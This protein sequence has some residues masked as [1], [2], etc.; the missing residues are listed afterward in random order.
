MRLKNFAVSLLISLMAALLTLGSCKKDEFNSDAGFRLEFSTDTVLFDTVFTSVGSSVRS[1]VIRNTGDKKINISKVSLAR[2]TSSPFRLN[3]D[4]TAAETYE[5]LEIGANDSAYIFV[6]VTIDPKNASNP[7]IETDSVLFET[8]GNLQN[9][10]LVAWGQDAYFH[11]DV[12]LSGPVIL[13]NDK[14]HVIY[15]KLTAAPDCDLQIP[16]GSRLYFHNGSSF[17]VRKGASLDVQGTI[18]KPVIFTSDRLDDDYLD[19]PG[20]WAGIWLENGCRNIRFSNTE[21]TNARIGIQ[22][23]STGWIDDE[24]LRLHNCLIHNMTNYGIRATNARIRATNCQITN[25]GANVLCAEKGGDYDFRNCTLARFFGGRG[26]P[27]IQLSNYTTDSIGTQQPGALKNAYFGNCIISGNQGS[28]IAL[29]E[30]TGTEFTFRF[31]KCIVDWDS[32]LYHGSGYPARFTDC[33]YNE[34]VKFTDPYKNLFSLDSLSAAIDVA[35][36][37]IISTSGTDISFDRKGVSRFLD[38]GPD[39]GAYE[40]VQTGKKKKQSALPR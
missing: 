16:E 11:H 29:N 8:N 20:L 37:L 33:L 24:P 12:V 13:S 9:V 4:G 15:G 34:D 28:E 18:E 10:K 22:A 17:E 26:Y 36:P 7:L 30:L 40:R 2:G 31:D 38:A 23:D 1:M 5:N 19:L 35:S 25:C 21:I 27:A 3:I 6:K 14:P 32:T 39:L